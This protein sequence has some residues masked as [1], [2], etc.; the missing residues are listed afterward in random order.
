MRWQDHMPLPE[1]MAIAKRVVAYRQNVLV[2]RVRGLK[3]LQL[4]AEWLRLLL[5]VGGGR[6]GA[7][8]PLHFLLHPPRSQAPILGRRLPAARISLWGCGW[9]IYFPGVLFPI[10]PSPPSPSLSDTLSQSF[11]GDL[12]QFCNHF[13]LC[14]PPSPFP[15]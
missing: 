7:E 13:F 2:F 5:A 4:R 3:G 11:D 14:L 12:Q 10:S 9:V 8:P 6:A 15:L 1:A